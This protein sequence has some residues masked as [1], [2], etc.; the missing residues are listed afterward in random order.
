MR[1]KNYISKIIEKL[2]NIIYYIFNNRID[3]IIA[4]LYVGTIG[5]GNEI[6]MNVKFGSESYLI[7]TENN[8][9]L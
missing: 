8:V 1:V 9:K 5:K 7:E 2:R 3:L 6:F 4:S